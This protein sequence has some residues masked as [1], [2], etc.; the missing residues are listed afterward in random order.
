MSH[1]VNR[2]LDSS[3][4]SLLAIVEVE[5]EVRR[6]DHVHASLGVGAGKAIPRNP[7]VH[8]YPC[9]P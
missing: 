7:L 3:E 8:V 4:Q 9:P 1:R 6:A 5:A 2:N